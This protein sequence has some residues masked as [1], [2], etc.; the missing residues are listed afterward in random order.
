MIRSFAD[1]ETESLFY[2]GKS[3]RFPAEL[4]R[5]AILRLN[6]LD[7]A[8]SL[9]EMRFPTANRLE[10]LKGNRSSQWSVRINNQWRLCFR[11]DNGDA[12]DVEITDYH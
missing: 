12:F 6:Q 8:L 9:E 3:R 10:A 4:L 2:S 7:H 1:K 11:F 5:R